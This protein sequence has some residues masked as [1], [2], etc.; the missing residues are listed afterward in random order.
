MDNLQIEK[1]KP[2]DDKDLAIAEAHLDKIKEN[3]AKAEDNLNKPNGIGYTDYA[4]QQIKAHLSH[5]EKRIRLVRMK[6]RRGD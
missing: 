6:G 5:I 1:F 2:G 3:L 4:L